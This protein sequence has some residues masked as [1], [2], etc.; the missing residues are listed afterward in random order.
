MGAQV[1]EQPD[2]VTG[3]V[4]RGRGNVS[5]QV[6]EGLGNTR[7][8]RSLCCRSRHRSTACSLL[9]RRRSDRRPPEALLAAY[10][11]DP[12]IAAAQLDFVDFMQQTI[13]VTISGL[14]V[15]DRTTLLAD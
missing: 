15:P 3:E 1:L 5:S 4:S 8:T 13:A 6:G 14:L 7:S 12:G 11:A 9:R 10:A 2:A